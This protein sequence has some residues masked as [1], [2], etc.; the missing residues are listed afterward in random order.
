MNLDLSPREREL[1]KLG[2]EFCDKVLLP[3]IERWA[4]TYEHYFAYL[5]PMHDVDYVL[6]V[7]K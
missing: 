6:E 7:V 3:L 2:R 5:Y 4:N 1:A